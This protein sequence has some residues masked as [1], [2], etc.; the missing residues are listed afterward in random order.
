MFGLNQEDVLDESYRKALKM[1]RGKFSTTF[2]LEESSILK[3]IAAELLT[4]R[5][6]KKS[7]RAELYK[8][9]IYG[10]C[11]PLDAD[12]ASKS[13]LSRPRIVL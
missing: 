1:D 10:M 13:P 5:D 11:L 9:N 7:L 3:C 6:S 4:V 12:C 2:N 8:L